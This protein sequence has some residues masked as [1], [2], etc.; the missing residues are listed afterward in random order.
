LSGHKF[1][2]KKLKEFAFLC[3]LCAYSKIWGIPTGIISVVYNLR[4]SETTQLITEEFKDPF[5]FELTFFEEARW[6][7]KLKSQ[8]RSDTSNALGELASFIY[9]VEPCG[10]HSCYMRGDFAFA[11]VTERSD[12]KLLARHQTDDLLLTAGYS[13]LLHSRVRFTASGLL[14]I[15]THKDTSL[16]QVQFG[17]GHL[18]FG[19]QFDTAVHYYQAHKCSI[20]LAAR[21]IGTIPRNAQFAGFDYDYNLGEIIDLLVGH[22]GSF[23]NHCFEFGYNPTFV[24]AS[25]L[26]PDAPKVE[27]QLNLI[28]NSY[29]ATYEY[30]FEIRKVNNAVEFG[31]SFGSD[32]KPKRTGQRLIVFGWFTWDVSF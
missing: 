21:L 5:G 26:S 22:H 8:S 18:G 14:G 20:R 17:T 19:V 15:P 12:G 30:S 11:R 24:V 32:V 25:D 3:C 10:G 13:W 6:Q 27:S 2:M 9:I 28:R 29:Y 7:N 1:L 16:D 23:G 4:V 31:I